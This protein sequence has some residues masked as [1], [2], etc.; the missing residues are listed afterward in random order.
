MARLLRS[1]SPLPTLTAPGLVKRHPSQSFPGV[2]YQTAGP[3]LDER[4][5]FLLGKVRY[6]GDQKGR[7]IDTPLKT[8]YLQ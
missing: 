6:L 5:G 4:P 1:P 3:L 2:R 7:C 8:I